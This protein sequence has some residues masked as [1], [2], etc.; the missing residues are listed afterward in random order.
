MSF[1]AQ[2]R[3]THHPNQGQN[4]TSFQKSRGKN[5]NPKK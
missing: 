4:S 1:R 5:V 2:H 3:Y